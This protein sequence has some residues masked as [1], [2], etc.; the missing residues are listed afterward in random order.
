LKYLNLVRARARGGNPDILPD[1]A[2]S[3]QEE[4]RQFIWQER[5]SELAFET[6][7]Y[8]DLKRQGRMNDVLGPLGFIT[9]LHELLPIPQ[10]E[11][12]LSE[13]MMRQNPNW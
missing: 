10:Q 1:R 5:R 6:L 11:I 2:T 7:R 8:F 12:D 13:G 3:N 9:G 4:L